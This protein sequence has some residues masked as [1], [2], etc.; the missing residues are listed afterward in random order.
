MANARY[1]ACLVRMA[2]LVTEVESMSTATDRALAPVFVLQGMLVPSVR[3]LAMLATVRRHACTE[4]GAWA[5]AA[6][7]QRNTPAL[8]ARMSYAP[9]KVRPLPELALSTAQECA[10]SVAQGTKGM[11][12]HCVATLPL[13]GHAT[14]FHLPVD[15]HLDLQRRCGPP[16]HEPV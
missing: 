5:P 4:R 10:P 12:E 14:L 15:V 1:H 11:R 3:S 6:S 9:I 8:D 7:V 13:K 2:A 16:R